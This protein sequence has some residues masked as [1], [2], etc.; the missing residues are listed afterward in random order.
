M[1]GV[2]TI[3]ASNRDYSQA[4]STPFAAISLAIRRRAWN[5]RVFTVFRGMP[6]IFETSP[7][8]LS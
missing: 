2:F 1:I 4:L 3:A 5:M 8:V 7:I 6:V